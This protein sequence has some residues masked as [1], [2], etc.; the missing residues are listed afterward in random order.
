MS[1]AAATDIIDSIDFCFSG[2]LCI[3]AKILNPPKEY[4]KR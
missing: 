3:K 1:V 2:N 4:P